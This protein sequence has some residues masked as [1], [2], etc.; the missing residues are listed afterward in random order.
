MAMEKLVVIRIGEGSFEQGFPVT[1]DIGEEGDRPH[2]AIGGQL[3]AQHK[4]PGLYDQWRLEY[5]EFLNLRQANLPTLKDRKKGKRQKISPQDFI[6]GVK[7]V[8]SELTEALNNWLNSETFRPLKEKFQQKIKP[9]DI[10]RVIIQTEDP[11]L[12]RLPWYLWDL[13]V[14]SGSYSLAEVALSSPAF[15]RVDKSVQPKPK[16]RILAILGDS[17]PPNPENGIHLDLSADQRFLDNLPNAE[18]VFL[19]EPKRHE[20][21]EQLW[22]ERGWDILFFAGHSSSQT[23]GTTGEIYINRQESLTIADLKFAVKKAIDRGLRLA[24]FNSCDGLG[25]ARD[26]AQLQIPEI[27]VMREPV[28]DFVAQEFLKH[29][30][31]SFSNGQ[32]LYLAVREARE[33]LHGLENLFP[34][35]SWLPVICQNLAE[36]PSNWTQLFI[37]K[38]MVTSTLVEEIIACGAK[39]EFISFLTINSLYIPKIVFVG[40]STVGKSSLTNALFGGRH[41]A[42][43]SSV[44]QEDEQTVEQNWAGLFKIVDSVSYDQSLE[45]VKNYIQSA[46]VIV[47]IW[48]INAIRR[49][50]AELYKLI[51]EFCKPCI[52]VL[53]KC[54]E[55]DNKARLEIRNKYK[56]IMS[57]V[58]LDV[59][60]KKG[61]NL[62]ELVFTIINVLPSN[63]RDHVIQKLRELEKLNKCR[64]ACKHI[65]SDTQIQA[66]TIIP[67]SFKGRV[68]LTAMRDLYAMMFEQIKEQYIGLNYVN[69]NRHYA[70]QPK[71]LILSNIDTGLVVLQKGNSI[72]RNRNDLPKASLWTRIIGNVAMEFYENRIIINQIADRIKSFADD[73]SI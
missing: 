31:S 56:T 18:T 69:N 57:S 67:C 26:L 36:V 72:I 17:S 29:F 51:Q 48:D 11:L 61:E 40:T 23:D 43:V 14:E 13:F 47:H 71:S 35:A 32:S 54:E 25:I 55:F 3:P 73:V 19:V 20:F 21:N 68:N 70:L 44:F 53:N 46:D 24:I 9:D 62:T 12:R 6:D 10:V 45:E 7:K 58:V 22:D 5:N 33:R 37:N 60:A 27:I 64:N 4:L 66:E 2:T 39:D 1:L 52:T 50:D 65:I 41:I 34:C 38:P 30:L 63:L 28:P 16:V 49:D 42:Q 59:S 15:E 8:A